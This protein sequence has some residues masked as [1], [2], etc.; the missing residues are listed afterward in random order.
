MIKGLLR[1]FGYLF[2][3]LAFAVL[4]VD[5]VRSLAREAIMLTPLENF[6]RLMD[7]RTLL[8]FRRWLS[9]FEGPL[10]EFISIG[11]SLPAVFWLILFGITFSW[12]GRKRRL[13]TPEMRTK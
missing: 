4:F 5:G 6:W 11:F 9:G 7:A 3:A 1:G 8:E 13:I 10:P 2:T 12:L